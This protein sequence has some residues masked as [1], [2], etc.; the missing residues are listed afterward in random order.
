[1]DFV[2]PLILNDFIQSHDI[3]HLFRKV[4]K[5]KFILFLFPYSFSITDFTIDINLVLALFAVSKTFL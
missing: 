4:G 2:F 5:R 1:M 3:I